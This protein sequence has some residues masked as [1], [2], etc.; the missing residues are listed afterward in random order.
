[1]SPLSALAACRVTS[2]WADALS[3]EAYPKSR[4]PPEGGFRG[5]EARLKP[6]R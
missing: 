5:A 4:K 3:D 1:M 6:W 2:R